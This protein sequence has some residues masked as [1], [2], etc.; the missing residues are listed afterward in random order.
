MDFN[1]SYVMR[2]GFCVN[3]FIFKHTELFVS[4]GLSFG[5]GIYDGFRKNGKAKERI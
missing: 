3:I 2:I 4:M 1:G 5:G